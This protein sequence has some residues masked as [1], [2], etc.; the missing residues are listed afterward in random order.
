[1]REMLSPTAAL[2]GMGLIE[3]VVLITDGRFS[4]GSTGAV[5]GHLSPE[6]ADGGLIAVV[7]NGD[8]IRVDFNERTLNLDVS[9]KEIKERFENL[10]IKRK[11]LGNSFL[12]RYS[13][14][15]QSAYT[16]AVLRRPNNE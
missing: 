12:G 10:S 15:V 16:G 8:A 14:F 2:V 7:K 5:I 4:G 11:D 3:D 13:H 6:A 1:M 9:E